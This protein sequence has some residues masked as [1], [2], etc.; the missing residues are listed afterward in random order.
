MPQKIGPAIGSV[1]STLG[2]LIVLVTVITLAAAPLARAHTGDPNIQ[3]TVEGVVPSLP[4]VGFSVAESVA[5]A[6][7]AQNSS[8]Q[9]LEILGGDGVPFL[10]LGPRGAEGNLNSPTFYQ[11]AAPGGQAPVPAR[12]RH[13]TAAP[14][15]ALLSR[16]AAWGW[17]EPR[18]PDIPSAADAVRSRSTPTTL[19]TWSIPLRYGARPAAVRGAVIYR[20]PSAGVVSSL[21]SSM[22]PVPGVTVALLPGRLPDLLVSNTGAQTLTILGEQG[23]PFARIGPTGV[24]VNVRSPIYAADISA[25]G[26]APPPTV[27]NPA[28]PPLYRSVSSAGTLDWFDPRPRLQPRWTVPVRIGAR[29]TAIT[30]TLSAQSATPA[31]PYGYPLSSD[32]GRGGHGAQ[33]GHAA[34]VAGGVGA[35]VLVLMA[36]GGAHRRR[37]RRSLEA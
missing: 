36:A 6:L 13:R 8:S 21:T 32:A 20:P 24:Q 5:S 27:S 28:A 31:T 26:G 7:S 37:R 29:T 4:G 34:V 22:H 9:E 16:R 12:A 23:E 14:S 3:T 25:R 15:W 17:Y 18:V 30:G 2:R 35:L 33:A 1:V 10:R 11:S 19:A